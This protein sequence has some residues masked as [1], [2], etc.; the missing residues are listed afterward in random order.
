MKNKI[1][2]LIVMLVAWAMNVTAQSSDVYFSETR[3]SKPYH[4]IHI[5]GEMNVKIV[6][7][8]TPGVTVEGTGYQIGNTIT[9]L[10]N[11]TLFVY[12]TNTRSTDSKTRI[13][14][15][16]NDIVLLE[17]IGKTKVDC[18]GLV[19]TDYLT[20]R[21]KEGAQIKL[22]VRALKVDSR[23]TG[24]SFIMLTGSTVSNV[25][26]TDGCGVIDSH[27][28]DLMERKKISGSVCQEC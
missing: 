13:V 27:L 19:N 8:E 16:A 24:C 21:A 17:V 22:D 4:F 26:A 20:V 28:L 15:N 7:D 25:E 3:T 1:T 18:S 10:R 5:S 9:M 12:Q 6:Q 23:V 2:I 11:D 14:I